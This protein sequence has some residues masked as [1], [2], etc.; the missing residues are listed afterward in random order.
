VNRAPFAAHYDFCGE[1]VPQIFGDDIDCQEV[2]LAS[3]V[4]LAAGARPGVADLESLRALESLAGGGF[5]LDAD[6]AATG[7]DDH[8]VTA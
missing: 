4:D 3:P 8:V 7:F 6:E 5:D 2:E 1:D